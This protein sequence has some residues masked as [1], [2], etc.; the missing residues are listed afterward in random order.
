[1]CH[2]LAIPRDSE[3]EH[4]AF[5]TELIWTKLSVHITLEVSISLSLALNIFLF[6]V[7]REFF[8]QY[9]REGG[10]KHTFYQ[11]V[12]RASIFFKACNT[13][14]DLTEKRGLKLRLPG[15]S[16][17]RTRTDNCFLHRTITFETFQFQNFPLKSE[18]R[19][20][21]VNFRTEISVFQVL[22]IIK[23]HLA[24]WIRFLESFA[25]RVES[26]DKLEKEGSSRKYQKVNTFL[27]QIFH[28]TKGNEV[29]SARNWKLFEREIFRPHHLVSGIIIFWKR[30]FEC[31]S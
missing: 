29:W 11:G 25:V 30:T 1:M 12:I 21:L 18:K 2:T 3:L 26:A 13:F 20:S 7:Q 8:R 9:K 31:I 16:A 14:G 24:K 5:H 17:F 28:Y 23:Y 15:T 6:R 19:R 4:L 10:C 27:V 22:Q